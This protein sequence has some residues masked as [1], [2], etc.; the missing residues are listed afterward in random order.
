MKEEKKIKHIVEFYKPLCLLNRNKMIWET[1]GWLN[2]HRP[3]TQFPLYVFSP[4]RRG[5][6]LHDPVTQTHRRHWGETGNRA[7]QQEVISHQSQAAPACY[8][9]C[10]WL[11]SPFVQV[12]LNLYE[13]QT[14]PIN[15]RQSVFQVTGMYSVIEMSFFFFFFY[16]NNKIH[17]SLEATGYS[18][19][20]F[21]VLSEVWV[22]LV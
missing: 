17:C 2:E 11:P 12:L 8:L 6:T 15:C 20:C 14:E 22:M 1:H 4:C 9:L 18:A 16:R 10:G 19:V 13:W 3:S 5:L 21:A 7:P